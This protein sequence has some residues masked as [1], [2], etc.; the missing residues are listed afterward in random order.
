MRERRWDVLCLG[1]SGLAAAWFALGVIRPRAE[2]LLGF[3]NF[4]IYAYFY[5]NTVYAW[6]ALREASGLLWNPYQSCGQPFFGIS[7]TG[8]LYPVNLVFGLLAREPA[9]LTSL[10]LNL[11][12]A[13]AG[14]YLLCRE[15]RLGRAASLC[16]A[17]AFQLSGSAVVLAA[18]GPMHIAG[19]AWLPLAMLFT[20]RVVRRGDLRD[21]LALG[22][23][24]TLQLLPGFPQTSFFTYQLVALRVLWALVTRQAASPLRALALAA[25]GLAVAPL[26]AAV[27]LLPSLEVAAES[28]R[29]H[30][31]TLGEITAGVSVLSGLRDG[32]PRTSFSNPMVFAVAVAML[33]AV[34]FSRVRSRPIAAF[35]LLVAALYTLLGMGLDTPLF[36][37]YAALPFGSA[38]RRPDR[39]LWLTS[40]ALAVLTALGADAILSVRTRQSAPR[41]AI[42]LAALLAGA[43][44]LWLLSQPGLTAADWALAAAVLAAAAAAARWPGTAWLPRMALPA[45]VLASSLLVGSAPFQS[46]RTGDLGYADLAPVFESVR[47]QLTSQERV[48]VVGREPRGMA[49]FN[50]PGLDL[51]AKSASLYQLRSIYDYEPQASL[52][53]ADF[54][55]RMRTGSRLVNIHQWLNV[56]DGL[57][58]ERFEWH[59]LDITAARFLIVDRTADRTSS[60]PPGRLQLRYEND[61]I[62]VY[63]NLSADPRAYFV[64]R[65]SVVPAE[66]RLRMLAKGVADP[67][68]V[69]LVEKEPHSKFRGASARGRGTV[70][71]VDDEPER[72]V[73]SGRAEQAGF[74]FLADQYASGWTARVNG[75]PVEILRANHAFRLVQVPQGESEVVFAY[76]PRG[77]W[78]GAAVSLATAI[79]LVVGWWSTRR[80]A[81]DQGT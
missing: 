42:R 41:V 63:E 68:R 79:A 18:W 30:G 8:L 19:Y 77:L 72:V 9:L 39:F 35:Y 5:P 31:L 46:L 11:C 2:Q 38:F 55:E 7:T 57:M 51:M 70:E 43:L 54:F 29:Q 27:Q 52:A 59:L 75:E 36:A 1:A 49:A 25:L 66:R 56:K 74:V 32:I 45:I 53:Y 17:F 3:Q 71:F 60:A 40:F 80:S 78:P 73:L 48:F 12:I 50:D 44:L 64:P 65:V 21:A 28:I 4:D 22:V 67:R 58:P 13:G 62:R 61:R 10:M 76:R 34:A 24:L 37:W 23:V 15:L 47:A 14:A 16:G 69:A 33:A 81:R 6:R 26:L 20:E